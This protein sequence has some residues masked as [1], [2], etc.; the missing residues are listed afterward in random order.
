MIAIG[1]RMEG[2][3]FPVR[4]L[5]KC[6]ILAAGKSDLAHDSSLAKAWSYTQR[7]LT[8]HLVLYIFLSPRGICRRLQATVLEISV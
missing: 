3:F 1:V 4:V 8:H 6:G 7:R 5:K 2:A